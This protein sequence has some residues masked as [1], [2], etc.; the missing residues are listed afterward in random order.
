[1]DTLGQSS[2]LVAVVT[3][4]LGFSVLSRNVRNKLFISFALLTMLVSA[5]SISFFLEK[6]WPDFGFYR[7]HLF[8]NILLAPAGLSFIR[9]MVRIR[10]GASRRLLDISLLSGFA[11]SI[12]LLFHWDSNP[13]VL[14]MI[15]FSPILIVF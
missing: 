1:M 11:L 3:F 2:L 10:D 13:I 15:Y 4:A 9:M 6:V 5:W 8:F 7:L 14:Q 12:A